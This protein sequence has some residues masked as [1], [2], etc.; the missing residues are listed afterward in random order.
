MHATPSRVALAGSILVLGSIGTVTA[1]D[2][3]SAPTP[4]GKT[5][6]TLLALTPA[7]TAPHT[8]A[9]EATDP[10]HHPTHSV[11]D[12]SSRPDRADAP[13]KAKDLVKLGTAPLSKHAV[14]VATED[15]EPAA[16]AFLR[17][18]RIDNVDNSSVAWAAGKPDTVM[19]RRVVARGGGPDSGDEMVEQ[20]QR[21][22]A[23]RL[24]QRFSPPATSAAASRRISDPCRANTV[25]S[26]GG[27]G[28]W[29]AQP[30]AWRAAAE[31]VGRHRAAG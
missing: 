24:V 21:E 11:S 25:R 3:Q 26:A 23:R 28:A 5:S 1:V 7:P 18:A 14:T 20:A 12:R 6:G 15:V 22:F 13:V 9:D 2:L 31:Y 4:L 16:R 8:P 29:Q 19:V 10:I 30:G 17:R 27:P